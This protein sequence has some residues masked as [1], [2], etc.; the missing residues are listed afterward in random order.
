MFVPIT[1]DK[2]EF[3]LHLKELALECK[4]LWPAT[5]ESNISSFLEEYTETTVEQRS[6]I[7]WEL[8]RRLH[9]PTAE[10]DLL[11]FE[12]S[13]GDKLVIFAFA[14]DSPLE[15]GMEHCLTAIR[16]RL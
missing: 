10:P 4:N 8:K 11:F 6:D 7:I 15:N 1:Y 3:L 16:P 13:I 14:K 12:E 2:K 9:N 5:M